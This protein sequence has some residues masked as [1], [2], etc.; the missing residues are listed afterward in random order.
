MKVKDIKK[1]Y[2]T[3][4]EIQK[5]FKKQPPVNYL[6]SGVKEKSFGIIFGPSKS[7]KTVFCEN[8]ALNLAIGAKSYFGY[9]LSGKSVR[10]LF[11]GLEEYWVSR[12]E[13]NNKQFQALTDVEKKLYN[14]NYLFQPID[15]LS[16]IIK[17]S[18]W[19]K[20]EETIK[21]SN[22]KVVFIDSITRM[23][24][25]NLEDS[26]TAQEIMQKLRD[27][28]YRQQITLICI[29][30]TPKMHNKPINMDSIKGS[31]VFAQESDFAIGI[32]KV[33]NGRRYVKNVF[34]RY[35]SEDDVK[36]KEFEI[37][38]STR[39]NYL[40]EVYEDKIISAS[41][42]RRNDKNREDIVKFFNSKNCNIYSTKELLLV[43]L[44]TL[45]LKE[46]QI[47][48]YLKEL[49]EENKI[50]TP[51]RGYYTS[52]NCSDKKDGNDEEE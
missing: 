33:I 10:I 12:V 17:K 1:G 15:Y 21:E 13:R 4:E 2:L 40:E 7:G 49:V 36:I 37:L 11:I 52:I 16:L 38:P 47:K 46:R 26:K 44:V 18:H 42:R 27:I 50:A 5:E 6:Y 19:I 51:K 34:F 45:E 32:N 28:C 8:L 3:F 25:G 31:A 20:L 35:A 14:V 30:H 9:K 48:T 41:D 22:A 29:H 23:N 43:F 39:L 24:H